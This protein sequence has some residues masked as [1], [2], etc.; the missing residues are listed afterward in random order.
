[1]ISRLAAMIYDTIDN[2]KRYLCIHPLFTHVYEFANSR[3]ISELENGRTDVYRGIYASTDT[4]DTKQESE[5][6]MECHRK[7]IDIQVVASGEERIG[8]CTRR[9]CDVVKEYDAEKDSEFLKGNPSFLQ[10]TKIH[11][12]ILFPHDAHM[13][14]LR[15]RETIGEPVKKIVFKVPVTL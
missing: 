1:M 9:Q 10:L 13:P 4:Y 7:Y 6:L 2:F 5:K 12:A 11:F 3:P 15:I 14:G 8:V